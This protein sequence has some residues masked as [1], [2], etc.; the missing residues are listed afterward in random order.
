MVQKDQKSGVGRAGN[1]VQEVNVL[2]LH[3][4]IGNMDSVVFTE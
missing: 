2:K 4:F 1:S 3:L